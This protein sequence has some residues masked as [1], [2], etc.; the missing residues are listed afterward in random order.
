MQ[1]QLDFCQN[2]LRI[3]ECNSIQWTSIEST[4][5]EASTMTSQCL[6]SQ[7]YCKCSFLNLLNILECTDPRITKLPDNFNLDFKPNYV[8][9]VGSSIKNLPSNSFRISTFKKRKR[10]KQK[11]MIIAKNKRDKFSLLCSKASNK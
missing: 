4:V 10:K 5:T 2:G 9:F 8:N 7:V 11:L 1:E 6:S 3:D